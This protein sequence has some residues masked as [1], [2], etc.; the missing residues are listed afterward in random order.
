MSAAFTVLAARDSAREPRSG[1][2]A[3]QTT[4]RVVADIDQV[5]ALRRRGCRGQRAVARFQH[6]GQPLR[7]PVPGTDG[8]QRARDIAHHVQQEGVGLDLDREQLAGAIHRDAVEPAH[9]GA[10]LAPGAAKGAEVALAEQRA[11][12][13]S[14]VDAAIEG[15]RL[16]RAR[17]RAGRDNYLVL[18]EAQR[19]L[20]LAQQSLVATQL[21][22][23]ANRVALY[24]VLGGG[25]LQGG[26]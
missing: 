4:L 20:Y 25:W 17:Y 19:A 21:A 3:R 5:E 16:S 24:K 14:A 6:P 15:D 13:Q 22:E 12:R 8:Q 18:L 1:R 7:R 11:A 26:P 2:R 9:R 10:R 23:Q